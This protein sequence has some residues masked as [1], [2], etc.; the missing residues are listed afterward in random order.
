MKEETIMAFTEFFTQAAS[1]SSLFLAGYFW[2][3]IG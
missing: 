2:L 3:L 1:L